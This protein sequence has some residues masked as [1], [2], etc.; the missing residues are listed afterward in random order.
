MSSSNTATE[1][2]KLLGIHCDVT[3][4]EGVLKFI[5]D[6][7]GKNKQLIINNV[8]IHAFNLAYNDKEFHDT[9]EAA[10]LVFVDGVGVV[11]GAKI[12]GIE[13]GKRITPADLVDDLMELCADNNWPIFLLGDTDDV[14]QDFVEKAAIEHPNTVFAG[15]HHGFFEKEGAENDAVIELV[16][17][18][19]AEVVLTF[20]SMPLQEKWVA[21]NK[22]KLKS[23]T[24]FAAGGLARIYTGHIA[25]APRWMTDNGMEWLYRLAVQRRTVW[26]RYVIGNPLFLGR[27]LLEKLGLLKF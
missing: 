27:V 12:K 19:S 18:S 17:N 4:K 1:R 8:N 13:V 23:A 11:W 26:R 5:A 2:P 20:M 7:A 6:N 14:L 24:Y 25:R 16:N 3:S 10:D 21:R 15:R 22:H 9:I